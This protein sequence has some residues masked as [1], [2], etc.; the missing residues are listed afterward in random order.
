MGEM[1]YHLNKAYFRQPLVYDGLQLLQIGRMFC[2]STTVIPA[3]VHLECFELTVVTEGEGKIYANGVP[4]AV[5][6][7][8]IYLSLPCDTHKIEADP[9]DPLKFDFFAFTLRESCFA[10]AFEQISQNCASPDARVLRDERIRPLISSAIGELEEQ[11]P[12]QE[13]LLTALF[14]QI[15]IYTVRGFR[16]RKSARFL[17]ASPS[18]ALCYRMMHYIDTHIYSMKNLHELAEAL[19]Y[20]YGYLSG[21]YR[22]TTANTLAEYYQEKKLDTARQLLEE[23]RLTVTK[24]AEMLNY[25]S[26][27]ALSKAFRKHY[28]LSPRAY[29]GADG[30][31]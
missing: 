26:V 31:K 16:K 30:E 24:I 25:G 5:R 12:Y 17:E 20:S 13:E 1:N 21:L 18:E 6:K 7:G 8:D 29:C 22:R 27:Y 2:K 19:G 10:E 23:N 14:R 11:D 4:T 9:A 28:G 3:H 15:L